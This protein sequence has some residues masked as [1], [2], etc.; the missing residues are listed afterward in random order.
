[1]FQAQTAYRL[2]NRFNV[3][4]RNITLQFKK[5]INTTRNN[6]PKYVIIVKIL[7]NETIVKCKNNARMSRRDSSCVD[8]WLK[9][10]VIRSFIPLS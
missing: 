8:H 6:L 10:P 3:M 1:M 4:I 9:T 2:G 7:I 5:Y